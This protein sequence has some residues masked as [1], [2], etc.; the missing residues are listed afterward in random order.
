MKQLSEVRDRELKWIQPQALKQEFELLAGDE[1]VATL[2]FKTAFG[3]LATAESAEGCWT[4]KRVG[5]WHPRVTI[6]AC[7]DETDLAV[8]MNRTWNNGG[9]LEFPDGRRYLADLNF[10]AT[11]YEFATETGEVVMRF[12]S[13][14]GFAHFSA[15]VDV[16]PDFARQIE[17]PWLI[18]LGWYL[19]ILVSWDSSAAVAA[20]TA[21][22]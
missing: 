16:M 5:F 9:T 15:K 10:W 11:R 4:F 22:H 20:T 13:I 12:T 6:R 2:R 18:M 19:R 17:M 1:V 8:F 7:G 14:G 21:A 3:T